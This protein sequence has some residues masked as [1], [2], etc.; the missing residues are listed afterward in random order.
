MLV[1]FILSCNFGL[2][3]RLTS[4]WCLERVLQPVTTSDVLDLIILNWHLTNI[5]M[6]LQV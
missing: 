5:E 6:D 4:F 2:Y 1:L 3:H